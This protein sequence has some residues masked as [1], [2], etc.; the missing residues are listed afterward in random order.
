MSIDEVSPNMAQLCRVCHSFCQ[1]TLP[2]NHSNVC[3]DNYFFDQTFQQLQDSAEANCRLC[4]FRISSLSIQKLR[5][6]Q[7]S[8][9]LRLS[10]CLYERV[11]SRVLGFKYEE[12]EEGQ[13]HAEWTWADINDQE[14]IGE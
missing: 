9:V 5:K 10:A 7:Q 2:F 4:R 1:W 12:E 3:S 11:T 8:E 6:S 14:L 13:M